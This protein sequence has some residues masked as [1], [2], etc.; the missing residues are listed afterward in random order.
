MQHEIPTWIYLVI[1]GVTAGA[2]L[3][4]A[5]VL[6]GMLFALKGALGRLNEVS[7]KAEENV[8]PLLATSRTLLEEVSPKLRVAA[9]N[10][11]EISQTAKEISVKAREMSETAKAE[12]TRIVAVLD[13]VLE[14]VAVQTDRVDEIVTGTLDSVVHATS[15]LQKAVSGPVRQVNAVLNGLK[16]GFDVLRSKEREAHAAADGDHFV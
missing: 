8:L 13:D 3:L 1:S 11:L 12:S 16:A 14:R 5:L 4:Q 10:A 6:V 9:Q 15:T 2:V 7:K